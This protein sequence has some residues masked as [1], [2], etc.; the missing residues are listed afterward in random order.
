MSRDL[1]NVRDQGGLWYRLRFVVLDLSRPK[2]NRIFAR[3]SSSE[4]VPFLVILMIMKERNAATSN[5]MYVCL[6]QA[7]LSSPTLIESLGMRLLQI[8]QESIY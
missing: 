4:K 7:L 8:L 3:K 6:I 5:T 1:G 2:S